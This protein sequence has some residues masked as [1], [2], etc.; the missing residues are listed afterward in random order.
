MNE[1]IF[2]I[3]S[4]ATNDTLITTKALNATNASVTFHNAVAANNL[5]VATA[6]ISGFFKLI[7]LSDDEINKIL[8]EKMLGD[9]KKK[10]KKIFEYIKYISFHVS[11]S[12]DFIKRQINLEEKAS[13]FEKFI[14]YKKSINLQ[15]IAKLGAEYCQ[16]LKTKPLFIKSHSAIHDIQPGDVIYYDSDYDFSFGHTS[17]ALGQVVYYIYKKINKTGDSTGDT[18]GCISET[19]DLESTQIIFNCEI[20]Y[21]PKYFELDEYLVWFMGNK[22]EGYSKCE[23]QWYNAKGIYYDGNSKRN[24]IKMIRY[25]G[26]KQDIVR[27][28]VAILSHALFISKTISF[29]GFFCLLTSLSFSSFGLNKRLQE[30]KNAI[31]TKTLVALCSGFTAL[32]YQ[33]T[34]HILGFTNDEILEIMPVNCLGFRPSDFLKLPNL[35]SKY[36]TNHIINGARITSFNIKLKGEIPT[37][38]PLLHFNNPNIYWYDRENKKYLFKYTKCPIYPTKSLLLNNN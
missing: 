26:P 34:F 17:I 33:L 32:V 37:Q 8:E 18:A 15:E 7:K 23:Q 10:E 19:W 14:N 24:K 38:L 20:G 31:S 16:Y 9:D 28:T 22:K 36:W 30:Y 35:Y 21:L 6:S 12:V 13:L 5:V 27:A 2:E 1:I 4:D 3:S 29:S 25:I 11:Y